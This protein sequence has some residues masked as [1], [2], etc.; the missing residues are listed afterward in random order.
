MKMIEFEMTED[1]TFL[2]NLSLRRMEMT[3]KNLIMITQQKL[4]ETAENEK[5]NSTDHK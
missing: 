3:I 2:I 4:M 5:N 1:E